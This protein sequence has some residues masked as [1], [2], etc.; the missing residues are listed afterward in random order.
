MSTDNGAMSGRTVL[1][2]LRQTIDSIVALDPGSRQ[3]HSGR[4][5]AYAYFEWDWDAAA[6][7]FQ[8]EFTGGGPYLANE[9][10]RASFFQSVRGNV[11]SA[12]A[13]NDIARRQEP[14][15]VRPFGALA[16][17]CGRR[18]ADALAR[19]ERALLLD[20]YFPPALQ[21]QVLALTALHRDSAAVAIARR[22]VSLNPAPTL[23]LALVVA[24]AGADSTTALQTEMAKLAARANAG[25][26]GA[27]VMFRAYAAIG[28]RDAAFVWLN[29]AIDERYYNVAYL[30][31][32]PL[33]DKL[34]PDP[35]FDAAR[36]RAGLPKPQ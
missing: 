28:D 15:N 32:D 25:A 35:R 19:S 16:A 12:L 26:V 6:R 1:P 8:A 33:L 18:Y 27:G 30:N 7:E 14:T 21:Y 11:D 9:Y 3:A 20:P 22:A 13:L 4:G 23:A 31:V 36:A 34:R 29:R 2:L 5:L 24:L 17:Y 10:V